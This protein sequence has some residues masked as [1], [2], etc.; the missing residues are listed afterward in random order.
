MDLET[1]QEKSEAIAKQ[2]DACKEGTAAKLSEH[3][4]TDMESS[5]QP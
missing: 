1:N 2:Q 4:R 5:S 3:W